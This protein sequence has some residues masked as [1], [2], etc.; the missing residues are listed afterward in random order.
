M[1]L[2][3]AVDRK[4]GI[5][6]NGKLL[7]HIPEDMRFFKDKTQGKVVIMGRA[8]LQ[9]LPGGV[10]LKNRINIVLSQNT[11]LE[12]DGA[13]VCNSIDSL[14]I[15]L[16]KYNDNDLFVIGGGRIYNLLLPFCQT[17][18]ITKINE[19]FIADTYFP[20]LDLAPNWHVTDK[21]PTKTYN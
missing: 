6:Y 4:W 5:G 14:F 10:P 12:A 18:Y 1:N 7:S 17:A 16:K 3:A 13:I 19:T 8:T 11:K 15:Q 2:I 20:N 21:S 9:S